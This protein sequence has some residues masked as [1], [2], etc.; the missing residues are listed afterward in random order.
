M[1]KTKEKNGFL[2]NLLLITIFF[3]IWFPKAGIKLSEIPLT[4]GNVFLAITFFFWAMK[5]VMNRRMK[6]NKIGYILIILML[7]SFIKYLIIGEFVKNIGYIIPLVVYPLMF[8]IAYDTIDTKEKLQKVIKVICFGFFFICIYA[9][10]QYVLGIE[11]VCIP[12]LTVNLS[13]Y[14]TYGANWYLQKNNNN[15]S[16]IGTKIISTFQNGNLYGVNALLIYPI[17]YGYLKKENKSF[18]MYVSLA[19]FVICVFLSLSRSC[20]LGI[21]LFM[22]FGIFLESEKNK[23]SLY[24]KAIIIL[25]CLFLVGV[26]FKYFPSIATRFSSMD[27]SSIMSM[28]GRTEGLT[29]VL[30]NF[31]QYK[32]IFIWFIGSNGFIENVGLAY[33]MTPL[34][35][36]VQVGIIGIV[37]FYGILYQ[38]WKRMNKKKWLQNAV[39]LS[40][41]IWTIVGCI[42]GAFW[43]PPTAL[44]IFL[45]LALG[46]IDQKV[47]DTSKGE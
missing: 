1:D 17:V 25:M 26:S 40:I 2:F 36:L 31:S 4:V 35:L 18:L 32:Y 27:K 42:E 19:L 11:K 21:I 5:K 34:A 47:M 14:T 24:R 9:L 38:V 33:E 46:L 8:I 16:E 39:K 28:S 12:G 10:L 20:W 13:D 22:L 41:F 7:Y 44:N 15:S 29:E 6:I 37:L 30:N 23:N 43:L 45:I 3:N